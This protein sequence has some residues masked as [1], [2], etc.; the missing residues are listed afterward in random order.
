LASAT[1]D[2][3]TT[4]YFYDGND[5]RFPDAA[6]AL[7]SYDNQDRIESFGDFVFE[8]TPAGDV[9]RRSNADQTAGY[10]L[11]YG[12]RGELTRATVLGTGATVTYEVDPF[13]RRVGRRVNG[14][15]PKGWLYSDQLKIIAEIDNNAARTDFIYGTR[16][17]VPD[18]MFK[19]GTTFYR[20]VTDHL[21]S[22]RLVVNVETGEVVQELAYD[23]WGKVVLDSNPGFQPFGFAGGLYDPATGLVRFGARDYDPRLGRWTS[24]DPIQ[25]AGG[26]ANLYVYVGNDP[27]NFIDPL[28]LRDWSYQEVQEH[29]KWYREQLCMSTWAEDHWIMYNRHKENGTDDMFFNGHRADRFDITGTG[30]FIDAGEMG[31]FLA[32]YGAGVN[33]SS[34]DLWL[35]KVAGAVYHTRGERGGWPPKYPGKPTYALDIFGLLRDDWGSTFYIQ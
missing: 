28:G 9:L 14:G 27:V 34:F 32:G 12:P 10:E 24:K 20:F 4:D 8:S 30:D 35:V 3:N 18:L 29:L 21:G 13:G 33:N 26:Q 31:N 23:P 16:E 7:A 17:N 19:Y 15:A 6:L 11:V 5:N 25:F 1:V 22:V 2:A